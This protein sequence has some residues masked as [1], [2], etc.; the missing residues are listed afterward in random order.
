MSSLICNL[1]LSGVA[2]V[3]IARMPD[4][5]AR[6][7]SP[8]SDTVHRQMRFFQVG[9]ILESHMMQASA[10]MTTADR[11]FM[12][13]GRRRRAH[14]GH[15]SKFDLRFIIRVFRAPALGDF[16]HQLLMVHLSSAVR[17]STRN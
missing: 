13:D 10:L 14:P 12:R 16:R 7:C 5:L 11:D 6:A 3:N 15:A 9:R 2:L 17:S 8:L 4:Y 1:F